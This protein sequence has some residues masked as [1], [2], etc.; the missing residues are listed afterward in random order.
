MFQRNMAIN[1]LKGRNKLFRLYATENNKI[2][3]L[4]SGASSEGKK[5]GV[6]DKK[7][8]SKVLGGSTP[9]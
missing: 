7:K 3:F 1:G 4:V 9:S 6:K 2:K 5:K 8:K